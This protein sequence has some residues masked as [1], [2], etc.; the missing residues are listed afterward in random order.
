MPPTKGSVPS[1]PTALRVISPPGA[2]PTAR[3]TAI[4]RLLSRAGSGGSGAVA[5][6]EQAPVRASEVPTETEALDHHQQ[7]GPL[8]LQCMR[9]TQERT[10]ISPGGGYEGTWPAEIKVLIDPPAEAILEA[11]ST[12][13]DYEELCRPLAVEDIA[14]RLAEMRTMLKSA[15]A[16]EVDMTVS[17][18]G[19]M[20]ELSPYPADLVLWA[21]AFWQ[22]T[23]RFYPTPSE[24]HGLIERRYGGR[25]AIMA[26]LRKL[27]AKELPE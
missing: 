12:L 16:G 21:L 25:Q 10:V 26:A 7:L 5:R 1:T 4:G 2:K 15:K 3:S 18:H 22:K 8:L 6:W 11:R 17:I 23:E 27:A 24:I 9:I 19:M 14:V 13:A 20:R